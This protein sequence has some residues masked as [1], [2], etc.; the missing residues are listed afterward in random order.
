[1]AWARI[2]RLAVN[3]ARDPAARGSIARRVHKQD[4]GVRF[5]PADK[6]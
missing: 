5:T 4:T 1:M 3:P 6:V 2:V